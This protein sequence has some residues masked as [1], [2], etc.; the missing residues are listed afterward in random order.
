MKMVA[1]ES[2][3]FNEDE[4]E[5][6]IRTQL[7]VYH[8]KRSIQIGFHKKILLLGV[9]SIMDHRAMRNNVYLS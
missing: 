1:H 7:N 2:N 4:L 6:E 8:V 9:G 5:E 3:L